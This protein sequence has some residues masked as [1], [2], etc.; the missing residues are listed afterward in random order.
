MAQEKF[1]FQFFAS[2][3][4]TSK[5]FLTVRSTIK[6]FR[7][8]SKTEKAW[9]DIEKNLITLLLITF[10][11]STKKRGSKQKGIVLVIGIEEKLANVGWVSMLPF[12]F[13]ST[14]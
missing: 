14:Y 11:V 1:P 3:S 13:L 8:R 2:F 4:S 12:F 6:L 7:L 9:F 5:A 10:V